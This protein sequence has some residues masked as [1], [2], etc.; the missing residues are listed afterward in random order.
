MHKALR[1]SLSLA[2]AAAFSSAAQA[3]LTVVSHGGANKDAQVKAFYEPYSKATGSRVIAGEFN[4]ELAKVKV[5]VDTGSVSWDV[6]ELE[7]PE[8]LRACDEGLLEEL[9]DDPEIAALSSQLLDGTLQTC[10]AGIFVWS[11]VLAY[12]GDKL[13]GTPTGWADFWDVEKFPG[14]R[15]LRKGAFNTLE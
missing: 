11:T 7:M 9:E 10:G 3:D 1:L 12:N 5:M 2:V 4:G 14:K 15:A 13:K 6:V 8:L